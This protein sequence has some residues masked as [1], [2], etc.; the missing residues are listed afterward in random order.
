MALFWQTD[1]FLLAE[2]LRFSTLNIQVRF[3]DKITS[4][5][6]LIKKKN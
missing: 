3:S 2:N 6:K 4:M 5:K 1:E